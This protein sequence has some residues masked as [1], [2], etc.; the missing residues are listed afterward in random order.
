MRDSSAV[1][2]PIS[3]G[4]RKR[5]SWTRRPARSVE[6]PRKGQEVNRPYFH[7]F[8]ESC[9]TKGNCAARHIGNRTYRR[10]RLHFSTWTGAEVG[11]HGRKVLLW[12]NAYVSLFGSRTARAWPRCATSFKS[13][14]TGYKIFERNEECGLEGLTDRA[15]RPN[16]YARK[17]GR[18]G[19]NE[20][21]RR[22]VTTTATQ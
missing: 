6:H 14:Q 8:R 5:R 13:P 17:S 16:R 18:L 2:S 11:C 12:M 19:N 15:R 9:N 21:A 20:T 3:Q 1:S 4:P 7:R 22:L 10:D